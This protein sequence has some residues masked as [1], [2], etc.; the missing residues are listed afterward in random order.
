MQ[1]KRQQ[2]EPDLEQGTGSKLGKDYLKVVYCHPEYLTS[3][4][5]TSCK[6][7]GQRV[8]SWNKIAQRNINNLRY[9][10]DTTLKAENEEELKILLM[11]M[12]EES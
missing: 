3:M 10:D 6:I 12:N 2:L 9:I 1:V 7:P 4:E 8:I 5:N 11:R